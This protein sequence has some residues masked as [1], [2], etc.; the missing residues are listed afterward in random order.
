M[1]ELISDN[2]TVK[3][4]I[5]ESDDRTCPSGTVVAEINGDR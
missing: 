3:R 5:D 4:T 1:C 2:P